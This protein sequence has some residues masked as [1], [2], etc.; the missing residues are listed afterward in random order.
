MQRPAPA[1]PPQYIIT[2]QAPSFVDSWLNCFQKR[3]PEAPGTGGPGGQEA[4]THTASYVCGTVL[5][6]FAMWFSGGHFARG[7]SPRRFLSP[8]GRSHEPLLR[9]L[10][11]RLLTCQP[12]KAEMKHLKG[13]D[14]LMSPKDSTVGSAFALTHLGLCGAHGSS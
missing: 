4:R 9:S 1:V 13:R 3:A 12:P 11:S 10:S 2:R 5:Q 14:S 6:S 8:R 7:S